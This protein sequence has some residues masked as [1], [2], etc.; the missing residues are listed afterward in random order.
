M[1][2]LAEKPGNKGPVPNLER[3][4]LAQSEQWLAEC[5]SFR[6]WYRSTFLLGEPS[7]EDEQVADEVQPWMIRITRSLL[8]QVLD[9][10]F[11]YRH[12]SGAME[13]ALWQL[14][15]DWAARRGAMREMEADAILNRVFPGHAS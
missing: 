5:N 6:T 3:M 4:V 8:S 13:T 14:E 1:A 7:P 11:P 2:I 9:P 15:E 10:E 12:L